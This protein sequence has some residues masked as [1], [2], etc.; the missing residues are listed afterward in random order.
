MLPDAAI[1]P[2]PPC[3]EQSAE[4]LALPTHGNSIHRIV[5]V[6]RQKTLQ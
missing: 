5:N 6:T 4:R 1:L 3:G 2:R